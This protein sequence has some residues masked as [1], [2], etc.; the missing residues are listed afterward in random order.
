MIFVRI[1]NENGIFLSDDF[2][3]ELTANTIE[4]PCPDGFILPR[5]DGTQ[6]V[7]GGTAP[8]PQPMQ[9]TQEERLVALEAAM[10]DVI[11]GGTL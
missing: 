7:E 9:P 5:W 4:T 11:M 6:W 1:I 10:L 3:E 8:T 2:V